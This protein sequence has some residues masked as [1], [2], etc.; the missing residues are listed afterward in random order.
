MIPGSDKKTG[1]NVNDF[2]HANRKN[3]PYNWTP[4]SRRCGT[5]MVLAAR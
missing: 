2:V 4:G 5:R 3:Y 1:D